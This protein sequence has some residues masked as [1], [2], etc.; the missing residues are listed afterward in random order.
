MALDIHI[1]TKIRYDYS[2]IE[3]AV[4]KIG[5]EMLEVASYG[6]YFL[7][8][9]ENADLP[10]AIGG[11]NITYSQPDVKQHVFTIHVENDE[12]IVLKAFKDM[13]SMLTDADYVRFDGS[14]GMMGEIGSGRM[15]ARDGIT[16]LE[17]PN[18]F[19]AEWQVRDNEPMLF[20][21]I[22]E[23]QYPQACKLPSAD[24]KASRRLGATSVARKAAEEACASWDADIREGCIHDVMAT[25]DVDLAAAGAF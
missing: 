5:E 1:R 11:F 6:E 13:V 2:Y 15:F 16:V 18:A 24:A 12:K 21:T 22:R 10:S 4:V 9:V 8:G 17:E 7:N 3:S 23:P 14:S 25:G 20:Q 19:G